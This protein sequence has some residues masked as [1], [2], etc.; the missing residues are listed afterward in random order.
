MLKDILKNKPPHMEKYG[1][2]SDKFEFQKY[3]QKN[4]FLKRFD[5]MPVAYLNLTLKEK[6]K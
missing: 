6:I 1:P 2:D 5:Q 4:E 3:T